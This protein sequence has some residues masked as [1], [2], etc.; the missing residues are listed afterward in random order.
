MLQ[1]RSLV[2][3]VSVSRRKDL[4]LKQTRERRRTKN[5]CI[6]YFLEIYHVNCRKVGAAAAICIDL[7]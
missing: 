4:D 2:T 6:E 1:N 7:Q 5:I 3:V